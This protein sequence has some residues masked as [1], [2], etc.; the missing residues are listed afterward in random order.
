[1]LL[2]FVYIASNSRLL[3]HLPP[4]P[5]GIIPFAAPH[6]LTIAESYRYKNMGWGYPRRCVSSNSFICNIY[7][8]PPKCCKQKTYGLAKP[9]TCNIYTKHGVPSFQPERLPSEGP[10]L[11]GPDDVEPFFDVGEV[12]VARGER[13][14]ASGREGGGKTVDVGEVEIGFEFGGVA[15]ELGVRRDQMDRQLGNLREKIARESRT[16]VAPHGIVHLAPI[17]RAHEEFAL[18][19]ESE[20]DELLDLFGAG[21][22]RR[23]RNDGAGIQN[24]ALHGSGRFM[25][26]G[27]S[28]FSLSAALLEE[29]FQGL[30]VFAE[31]AAQAADKFRGKRLENEPVLLFDEGHLGPFFDGVFAAKFRGD[32]QLA[33]GGYGRDFGLHA[34]SR[35]KIRGKYT[36]MDNVSQLSRRLTNRRRGE[37]KPARARVLSSPL[38]PLLRRRKRA[39]NDRANPRRRQNP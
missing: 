1:M 20:L 3:G 4:N 22:V 9:F 10:P 29:E 11:H 17:D 13:G 5:H 23:K 21:S 28:Q 38:L 7:G 2:C 18:A 30:G 24:D 25:I 12:P 32:D 6:P 8:P 39:R 36:R 33:F 19:I 14:F 37:D 26:W 34:R 16:L 15:R 31:A 27:A 35:R